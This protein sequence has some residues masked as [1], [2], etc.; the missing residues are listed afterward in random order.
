[1]E[2]SQFDA[3][4]KVMMHI[5]GQGNYRMSLEARQQQA[6]SED[7]ASYRVG[8]L[9]GTTG[10]VRI[11]T[12]IRDEAAE[13]IAGLLRAQ[14]SDNELSVIKSLSVDHATGILDDTLRE[15]CP[16]FQCLIQDSK[17]LCRM[18]RLLA[19]CFGFSRGSRTSRRSP[20]AM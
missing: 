20:R 8:C 19:L 15:I 11:V 5:K 6:L 4:V 13:T 12:P 18:L 9:R 16:A 7:E 14:L 3:T 10:A 1:M 2:H 17:H